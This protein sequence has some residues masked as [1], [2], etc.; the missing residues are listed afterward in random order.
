MLRERLETER[1]VLRRP[2]SRDIERIVEL[3]GNWTVSRMLAMPPY[4]YEQ[5][6]AVRFIEFANQRWSLADGWIY[7]IT[8]EDELVG[9]VDIS[10]GRHGSILGYWLGEPYWG[11]GLMTEA[12]RAMITE[13]FVATQEDALF[14][15]VF[16]D[17]P[18]S[19]AVQNKIGFEIT[20]E[21]SQLS[22]PRGEVVAHL[23][24][25]LTRARFEETRQ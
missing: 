17:N 24:T 25:K 8:Q 7:A 23:D 6:H 20:G 18:A 14:S 22:K 19:L 13:F 9:I 2:Q 1:L 3:L 16:K 5:E 4:P 11:Q 12:V 10:P 21:G 15:G